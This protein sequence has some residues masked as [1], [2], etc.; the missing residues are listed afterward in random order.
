MSL[1]DF[2]LKQIEVQKDTIGNM[3][4]V[5]RLNKEEFFEKFIANIVCMGLS[6]VFLFI[7][8]AIVSMFSKTTLVGLLAV[9]VVAY[10]TLLFIYWISSFIGISYAG[11]RRLHDINKPGSLML[12]MFI[13][14]GSFVLLY[15]FT[16]K[17]VKKNNLY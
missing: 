3:T 5:G 17:S 15:Y 6:L 13:P 1:M 4:S 11:A 12:L 14:F 16:L 8:A 2:I 9:V 7:L 10:Y